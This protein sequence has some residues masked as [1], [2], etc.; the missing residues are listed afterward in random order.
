MV[1]WHHRFIG[2]KLGLTLGDGEGREAW[3]VALHGVAK[4]QIKLGN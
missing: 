1:G 2:H 3:C 4:S